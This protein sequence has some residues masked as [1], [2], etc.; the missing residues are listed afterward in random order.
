MAALQGDALLSGALKAAM[1]AVSVLNAAISIEG[2]N[3]FSAPDN[4]PDLVKLA[5]NL[6]RFQLAF[7]EDETSDVF[8]VSDVLVNLIKQ[9]K[10]AA[11]TS[12]TTAGLNESI[13]KIERAASRYEEAY[14]VHSEHD[15]ERA[16]KEVVGSIR[17]F[18]GGANSVHRAFESA[19][20]N[21]FEIIY[22]PQ[23]RLNKARELMREAS[24]VAS[25]IQ[26]IDSQRLSKIA[27][28]FRS[29]SS[30]VGEV[31]IKLFNRLTR[32]K[33][34]WRSIVDS[35]QLKLVDIEKESRAR[36]R[37]ILLLNHYRSHDIEA[38]D[39]DSDRL[40]QLAALDDAARDRRELGPISAASL[41]SSFPDREACS[42]FD[43]N[44]EDESVM[45]LMGDAVQKAHL[46]H[47][48]RQAK[49]LDKEAF[50]KAQREEMLSRSISDITN[51]EDE[52]F[53]E[54]DGGSDEYEELWE[55]IMDKDLAEGALT[56]LAAEGR[57]FG[58][59]DGKP[60]NEWLM[61]AIERADE[62]IELAETGNDLPPFE[63]IEDSN[64]LSRLLN[65]NIVITGLTLKWL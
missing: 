32:M 44:T 43:P 22:D 63:R 39:L 40:E 46:R 61:F 52:S 20:R 56:D 48:E 49:L 28:H 7:R 23:L 17:F 33:K 29:N 11:E 1:D 5:E 30:L 18:I 10:G 25:L 31:K 9:I 58:L 2:Q 27:Q 57:E 45:E 47:Q 8:I 34:E 35:F 60:L 55:E 65:G 42:L 13:N 21:D 64:E 14:E 19:L 37:Q 24:D 51:P 54:L 41:L 62:L 59:E 3:S 6:E 15:M 53:S 38:H 16:G 50:L 26:N 4:K 36:N 12:G